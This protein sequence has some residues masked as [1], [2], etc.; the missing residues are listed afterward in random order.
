MKIKLAIISIAI[1]LTF[2]MLSC[3]IDWDLSHQGAVATIHARATLTSSA[4]QLHI[5]LTEMAK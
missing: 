5:Q 4:R 2:L 3:V 1:V